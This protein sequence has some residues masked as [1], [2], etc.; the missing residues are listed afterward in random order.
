[1]TG[2]ACAWEFRR[3]LHTTRDAVMRFVI[4]LLGGLILLG[5]FVF[6]CI[7]YADPEYGYTVL[8]GVG[9]AFVIGIGTLVLGAV[10][11]TIYSAIAPA[12]FRGET[13]RERSSDLT[14]ESPADQS[15]MRLSD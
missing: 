7:E 1:M 13:L 5:V 14:L 6:A 2:F 11:M 12:Y 15:R 10:L 8:F 3:D 9:G 4:P